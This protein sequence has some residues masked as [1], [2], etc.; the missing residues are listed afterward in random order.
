MET[1][2]D[3]IDNCDEELTKEEIKAIED[4]VKKEIA[5]E[6]KKEE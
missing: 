3:I 4:K 2:Q 5:E 6:N 1:A